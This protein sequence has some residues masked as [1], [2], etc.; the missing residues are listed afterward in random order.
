MR[1]VLAILVVLLAASGGAHAQSQAEM[2]ASAAAAYKKADAELGSKYKKILARLRPE[3]VTSFREAERAW[4]AFR[5][6]ECDFG[7]S[8]VAGGSARP[9]IEALCLESETRTRIKQ[10]D[11]WL[12]CE[13]G[14][15]S[16][17]VSP[18]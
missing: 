11:T 6:A 16:C 18:P 10:F 15:M 12:H 2:T 8:G 1:S 3:Q 13:E 14:D 9:M 5:D 7:S 17:P 4:I